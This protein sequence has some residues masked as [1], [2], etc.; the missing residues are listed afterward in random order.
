M[1]DQAEKRV[2]LWLRSLGL[3]PQRFSKR[4]RRTKKLPDF[5]VKRIDHPQL[6][7][8]VKTIKEEAGTGEGAR[9]DPTFNRI[10]TKVHDAVGQFRSA[11]PQEVMPRMLVFV[12]YDE[13]CDMLDLFGVLTGDFLTGE[14][15]R[16]RIYS[17]FS[18][19]RIK[20]DRNLI[21][22]YVW[23][24]EDG[25]THRLYNTVSPERSRCLG[26]YLSV[27]IDAVKRVQS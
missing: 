16:H 17:R 6:L 22:V 27:D 25:S 2:E 3:I 23:M 20:S 14:G 4:E 10:S 19:G 9:S 1:S 13:D 21:D 12:N 15:S 11:D 18:E 8:E 24:E 7:I 26:S 5:H